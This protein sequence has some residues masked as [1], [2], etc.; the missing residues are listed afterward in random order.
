MRLTFHGAAGQVTGS[1][2]LLE[3]GGKKIL[4]DCGLYQGGDFSF[5][6]NYED[7]SFDPA[8]IDVVLVTH[9][10]I[11][12]TGRLPRLVKSGFRG[13]IISTPPTKEFASH[14]LEDSQDIN[15]REA[16]RKDEEP[17]FSKEDLDKT[18]SLWQTVDYRKKV[19]AGRAF[20]FRFQ[21][22]GHV[23]GS[24]IIEVWAREGEDDKKIVFSGDLGNHPVPLLP[25]P[26]RIN[27]AD[28]VI[29]ESTYGNRIHED[30]Q[31]RKEKLEDMVENTV[32]N[33][34]VLLI[35]A[36]ALER[37]QQLLYELNLLVSQ[38][39]VPELPVYVDS[40]L[41][42]DLTN[43]YKD[44]T[45]Y[46]DKAAR[47]LIGS[48]EKIFDFPNL[49]F[50]PEVE[51]SKKINQASSPKAIIAGSGMSTGGRILHHEKRY[52]ADSNNTL[53]VVC[54]QVAGSLG[55]RILDGESPVDI[56][57]DKIPVNAK[58][59]AIGGYSTHADQPRLYDW[60]ANFGRDRLQGVY[61]NHGESDGAYALAQKIRDHLALSTSV[62][63]SN[64]TFTL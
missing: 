62:P 44:F 7:F 11:D 58:V 56:Y 22:A 26:N 52:L 33:Q 36:F 6:K 31:K 15:R 41:A 60:V 1:C 42:I 40:P 25:D 29:V 12:H 13:D 47:D 18:F 43:S 34:G 2:S 59:K 32:A 21:N 46:Y 10:H 16:E 64:E 24:A 8:Q 30:P 17:L 37:T 63:S 38:K 14:L 28:Y 50:T 5:E 48:G 51:Q 9:A 49:H 3:A 4:I 55:R 20:S 27:N 61:V 45:S 53:L 57:G 54:Y 35:P 39:R 23:L 19:D